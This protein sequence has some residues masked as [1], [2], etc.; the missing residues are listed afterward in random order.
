MKFRTIT[1]AAA[2][3]T[4]GF[5]GAI[6]IAAPASA[7]SSDVLTP[8][9]GWS[10]VEDDALYIEDVESF[11]PDFQGTGT[12]VYGWTDD[13]FDGFANALSLVWDGNV[14]PVTVTPV[15]ADYVDNGLTTIV[16]TGTV[17]IDGGDVT[18]TST[19]EIQ[20]SFAR[21]SFDFTGDE[22]TLAGT[23]VVI[24]GE[25][26]SDSDSIYTPVGTHGL[27]SHQD[28]GGDPVLA[29]DVSASDVVFDAVDGDD[30]L[31]FSFPA[32]NGNSLTVGLL[33]YDVCSLDA[34]LA[35]AEAAV[36]TLASQFGTSWA[37]VYSTT[38][39]TVVNPSVT[40]GAVNI[41]MP[42][43]QSAA[44]DDWGYFSD[45]D[46]V[47]AVSATGLPAGL[48]LSVTNEGSVPVLHLT[49]TAPAGSY[50]VT[51][52]VYF[53]YE[54][55]ETYGEYPLTITFSFGTALAATGSELPTPAIIGAAV[56]LL[57]GAALVVTAATRRRRIH[58]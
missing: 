42:I 48:A 5:V 46:D 19:L 17:S 20:G 34:A 9:W 4:L 41:A 23:A 53:I 52:Q 38:C 6:A 14:F 3:L 28:G 49:G 45:P 43:T 2:A 35:Q 16:S 7:A 15:S 40:P 44:L 50:S 24:S 33:D 30:N 11:Y 57:L 21:W 58:S 12:P 47:W 51:A 54:D 37:P 18:V 10:D 22:A 56:V 26:G 29:W 25:L 55:G 27:V 8:G 32:V 13:A 31:A 39:A 36:P 1:A